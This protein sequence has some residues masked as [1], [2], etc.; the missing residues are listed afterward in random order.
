MTVE[1]IISIISLLVSSGAIGGIFFL[2]SRI[3]KANAEAVAAENANEKMIAEEWKGIA[4]RRETQLAEKDK[5]IDAL[6]AQI[7]DWRNKFHESETEKNKTTFE[8]Y[9]LKIKT[10]EVRG[11]KDREPQSGY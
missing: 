6:Y 7:N 1:N 3:R 8:N 10:C 5:K 11:C 2:R 4:E 9:M